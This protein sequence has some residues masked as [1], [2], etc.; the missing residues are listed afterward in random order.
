MKPHR[1]NFST[2]WDPA[3]YFRRPGI[4]NWLEQRTWSSTAW[5]SV[6][7]EILPVI[8][9]DQESIIDWNREREAPRL[10][11]QY[12]M[13]SCQSF[14]ETRNPQLIGTE[15]VKL[16]GLSLRTL[17]N[18]AS[19]FGRPEI[20]NWLEQRVWNPTDWISVRYEILPS[21]LGD[22]KSTI[23]WNREREAPRLESQNFVESCQS[24]WKARNP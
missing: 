21:I 13:E 2:L 11:S 20:H 19:H 18:P 9:G 16:H 1:L 5:V 6:L 22:Q 12:F 23:D 3:L 24:F 4:H 15:N 17:W 14:L 8:L 7:Y 10:E